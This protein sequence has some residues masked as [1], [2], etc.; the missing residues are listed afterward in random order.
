MTEK[1]ASARFEDLAGAWFSQAVELG[2]PPFL[3]EIAHSTPINAAP[4]LARYRDFIRIAARWPGR[5]A[6]AAALDHL[7]HASETHGVA[8]DAILLG[9]SFTDRGNPAPRDVDCLLLYRQRGAGAPVD[10]TALAG[11]RKSAKPTGV[12]VRFLPLDTDPVPLV[13]SLCYFT[14]LFCQAKVEGADARGG[15]GLVLLDCRDRNCSL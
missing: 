9:G 14:I 4:Y 10:A 11:L 15:R 12:D 3:T 5:E 8:V 6:L 7:L 1:P 13:K 2:F